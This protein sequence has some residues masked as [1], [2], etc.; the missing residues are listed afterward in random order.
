MRKVIQLK[1]EKKK[2][3]IRK[4]PTIHIPTYPTICSYIY[5]YRHTHTYIDGYTHIY[6]L[7]YNNTIDTSL[8]EP[9]LIIIGNRY[10]QYSALKRQI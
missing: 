2:E 5:I 10:Q 8:P 1:K 7:K 3:F 4:V 6:K 9:I